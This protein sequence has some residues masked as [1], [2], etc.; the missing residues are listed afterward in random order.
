MI[1]LD[2]AVEGGDWPSLG[3]VDAI[4]TRAAEAALRA[5]G[6][7]GPCGMSL[8]LADDAALR[9][10]NRRW[11]GEDKATNVLSFPAPAGRAGPGPR[12]LG[13]VAVAYGTLIREARDD[14]KAPADHLAH[15]VVH[16]VLHLLGRDHGDPDEADA[17]EALEVGAL[18]AIGVPDPYRDTV[19][20]G[21]AG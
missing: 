19:P 8:L 21:A 10:L 9:E 4:A 13:D 14:G 5:G 3:D 2:I 17:M 18:A 20:E 11:R 7:H 6:V 16:A 15:L 1:A 12:H